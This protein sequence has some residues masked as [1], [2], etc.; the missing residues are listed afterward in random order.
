MAGFSNRIYRALFALIFLLAA[1]GKH[2]ADKREI[3]G[4]VLVK[5]TQSFIKLMDTYYPC[6]MHIP[7]RFIPLMKEFKAEL[8]LGAAVFEGLIGVIILLG[9]TCYTKFMYLLLVQ[10]MLVATALFHNPLL[11][12]GTQTNIDFFLNMSLLGMALMFGT[13]IDCRGG[14]TQVHDAVGDNEE[15]RKNF[16]NK[17]NKDRNSQK[18]DKRRENRANAQRQEKKK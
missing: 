2:S 6:S 5:N 3:L 13:G 1:F 4:G 15:E 11:T 16:R 10:F 12:P 14:E 18:R 17:R 8:I 9:I 7:A